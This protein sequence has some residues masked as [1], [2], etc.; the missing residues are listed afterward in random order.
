MALQTII[1]RLVDLR[2]LVIVAALFSLCV[3]NN[4]GPRFVPLPVVTDRSA[5]H[6]LESP[7]STA[8]RPPLPGESDSFRVPMMAQA[9]KRTDKEPQPQPV[10]ATLKGGLED[11][12]HARAAAESTY[13]VLP[14]KSA[15]ASHPPGRAPPLRLI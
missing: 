1:S 2:A 11:P 3:S 9:Q 6:R 10:A 15:L 12:S 8:S 13:S 4:V 7:A 5:E 14:Q